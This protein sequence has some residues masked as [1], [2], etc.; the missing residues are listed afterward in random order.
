MGGEEGWVGTKHNNSSSPYGDAV[1]RFYYYY[2]YF[3]HEEN[4]TLTG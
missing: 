4:E 1:E 3:T 2:S